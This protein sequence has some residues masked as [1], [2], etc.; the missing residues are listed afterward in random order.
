MPA[1]RSPRNYRCRARRPSRA[2]TA[3]TS[4]S[5]FACESNRILLAVVSSLL[6]GSWLERVPREHL[7]ARS[8]TAPPARA[9]TRIPGELN[10]LMPN[11]LWP[12][13]NT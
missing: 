12:I 13:I 7:L 10:H 8:E 4:C 2:L 11:R 1:V 3:P 9:S 5:V 6:A